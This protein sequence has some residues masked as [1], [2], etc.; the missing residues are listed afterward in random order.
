MARLHEKYKTEVAS[1][2][3]QRFGYTNPMQAPKVEKVVINMIVAAR[4]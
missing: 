4:A 1:G 2:L 3:R